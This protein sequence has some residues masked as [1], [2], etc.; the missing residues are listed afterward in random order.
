M[1]R[2]RSIPTADVMPVLSVPDPTEAAAWLVR[3]FGFRVRLRIGNHR[4]Q[5]TFRDG[6]LVVTNTGWD[7][8]PSGGRGHSLLVRVDDCG[9][10]VAAASAAGATV[11]QEPTDQAYGERQAIVE[12]PW[13]HRW[14]LSQSIADVD[15]AEWGG[16]L[17][18]A[19]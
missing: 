14:M 18:A 4:V 3:A 9:A 15:P 12:D 13:G 19:D 11:I 7:G 1:I 6:A 10:V 16:E 8:A 5:L 17:A 2:N